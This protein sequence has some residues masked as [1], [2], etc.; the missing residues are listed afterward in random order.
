MRLHHALH[1]FLHHPEKI[2]DLVLPRLRRDLGLNEDQFHQVNR[3]IRQ[4]H[5]QLD[6]VRREAVS[7]VQKEFDALDREMN[8]NLDERQ[9]DK[10]KHRFHHVREMWFPMS[11]PGR[12]D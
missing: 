12:P 8:E 3:I 2:P 7:Q 6:Q 4:H 1:D 11:N 5:Q 9:R 10:W